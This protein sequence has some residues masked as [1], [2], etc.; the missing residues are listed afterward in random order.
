MEGTVPT[1]VYG[2]RRC[3]ASRLVVGFV[4]NAI[5]ACGA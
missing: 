1:N 5:A 4:L 2:I 3:A